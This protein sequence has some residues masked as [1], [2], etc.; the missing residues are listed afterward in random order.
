MADSTLR[1]CEV[2]RV[3][4]SRS[5][6]T[7]RTFEHGSSPGIGRKK[8]AKPAKPQRPGAGLQQR[9]VGRLAPRRS[10]DVWSSTLAPNEG[11]ER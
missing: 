2:R 10:S 8:P 3:C 6:D 9:S 11:R 1:V 4:L 5:R 7:T